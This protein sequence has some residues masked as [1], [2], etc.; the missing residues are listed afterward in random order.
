[1]AMQMFD[2]MA[3][4]AAVQ[5]LL[6][7]TEEGWLEA[8]QL[9]VDVCAKSSQAPVHIGKYALVQGGRA[10]NI[11]PMELQTEF[12]H[13]LVVI[14]DPTG[15]AHS[16]VRVACV[17]ARPPLT[18]RARIAIEVILM[19]MLRVAVYVASFGRW[20]VPQVQ[21]VLTGSKPST[22]QVVHTTRK[23]LPAGEVPINELFHKFR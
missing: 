14:S 13:H 11:L 23:D 20:R 2:R 21:I 4:N 12:F 10:T 1:M 3:V 15:K 17:S 6:S 18:F 9:T 19:S 22:G 16:V 5:L 7:E 8:A